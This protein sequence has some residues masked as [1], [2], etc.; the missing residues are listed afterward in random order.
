MK[1]ND[2]WNKIKSLDTSF[3]CMETWYDRDS[4][5]TSVERMDEAVSKWGQDDWLPT[6]TPLD[7]CLT[8]GPRYLLCRLKN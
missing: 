4:I 5:Q 8:L 2:Y 6:R 1:H 3:T 7:P